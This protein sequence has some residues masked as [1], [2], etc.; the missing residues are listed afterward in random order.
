MTSTSVQAPPSSKRA[1]WLM[2]SP[3]RGIIGRSSGAIG[4]AILL[5]MILMAALAPWLA[6]HDPNAQ[7]LL[8]RLKPPVFVG[9]TWKYVLGTDHLG[10]D[11]LSR[12]MYGA[13]I[14]LFIGFTTALIAGLIGTVVGIVAGFYDG[15]IR[16]VLMRIVD[17]F[18]A[19]P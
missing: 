18:L 4:V 9:G 7:S 8:S 6:P 2:A 11:L 1:G 12:L 16:S 10:R 3:L 5:L 14:S 19:I 17:V 15:W 13:R